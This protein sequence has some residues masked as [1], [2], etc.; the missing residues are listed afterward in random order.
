MGES[1]L[2]SE[3]NRQWSSKRKVL[4]TAFYK[5]KLLK[6]IEL[7]KVVLREVVEDW[8]LRF[9]EQKQTF[10]LIEEISLIHTKILLLCALGENI[11]N[12]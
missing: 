6:M 11:V 7:V 1:I 10:E 8:N 2:L 5:D 12:E 3:S 9:I 4:S